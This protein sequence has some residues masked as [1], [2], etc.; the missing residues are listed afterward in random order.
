MKKI[1]NDA[2]D[3]LVELEK[4][5]ETMLPFMLSFESKQPKLI[6]I[7]G[8]AFTMLAFTLI[9]L[10]VGCILRLISQ[11]AVPHLS[12][13]SLLNYLS[14]T[15][16]SMAVLEVQFKILQILLPFCTNYAKGMQIVQFSR[17]HI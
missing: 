16:S 8:T 1:K 12:L 6:S 10:L 13:A 14:S 7:S 9:L 4:C 2:E 5:S 17:V 3:V 15:D 11:N